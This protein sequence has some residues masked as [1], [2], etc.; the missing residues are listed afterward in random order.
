M[1]ID[2]YSEDEKKLILRQYRSL[3]RS[4]KFSKSDEDRLQIRKAFDLALD[5]HAGVKR[6]SGESYIFHPIAVAKI[7]SEEIGLG[8]TG[9][10]CALLH[11]VVED[12]EVTLEQIE[13]MFGSKIALIID[14]LTKISGVVGQTKS[15][16]AENFRK[17]LL[18]LSD[19]V[20]VILIKLADRLHN[21]RTLDSMR[22][23][24]QRKIASE[25]LFIYAPMAHRLGLYNIKTELEDLSLKFTEPELYHEIE[26]KLQ[27]TKAVRTRF[28]NQFTV[29]I[30]KSL[31]EHGINASIKGRT[32]SI[33]SIV[34]KIRNKK[35]AFEEI[36]DVF[37]IRIIIDAP[38]ER[39]K[40]EC[41]RV[42]SIV[43][44]FYKP[45][46]DRL[47]D[48]ISTPKS[49]GYES[50][51]TTVMSPTGKYVE[52]QI[53]TNRMDEIAE[54]G[55]AAHWKYKESSNQESNLDDWIAKIRELLENPNT[56]A[57]EFIDD[58]KLNLFNDE[59]FAF[60]PKGDLITMPK[61]ATA[62]DF[63]FE[64]HTE[65]GQHC[66]GAKVNHKLVPLSYEIKSG[67]QIE[68][69]T[70]K[71]KKPSEDW[72]SYAVTGKARA[73]IKTLLKEDKKRIGDDGKEILFRKLKQRK[74]E[75]NLQTI[76]AVK[77]FYQMKTEADLFYL[78]GLG[79]IDLT[80]L[81]EFK[82]EN[83]KVK[84]P[85]A[86]HYQKTVN[87]EEGLLAK[88]KSKS[89]TLLI[90]ENMESMDYKLAPCCNPIPGDEVFG[91]VTI[92]DGIK[93]HRINCPNAVQLMSNY[94]YRVV[95]A[96]WTTQSTISFL[97]GIRVTGFD[98]VGVVSEITNIISKDLN[99]NMRSISFD[100]DDG[101]FEGN[102][103]VFVHD[104]T[105]LT[106]L[107]SKI[108]KIE[109]VLSVERMDQ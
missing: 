70:S 53:R 63:A 60:T 27:K 30:Q 98:K 83:G 74:L 21:L 99:V 87:E 61:G 90:G 46:P 88:T 89:D 43:T 16:Q 52:V 109:G 15:I 35:V 95:K 62:L 13:S 100:S 19:D 11:D 69:I 108:S 41:W 106:N 28:I 3:L 8:T 71:K 96:R 82:V 97:A 23:D 12:T 58:F 29:P 75:N 56:N 44:D 14:G 101:I 17:V 37:A 66:M 86:T 40:S 50:L 24:K 10:V 20:R 104:T 57:I 78:I 107:S 49:N 9:I 72:L 103:K 55:Y 34:N 68:I 5:S 22:P 51:H 7:V 76:Q 26:S 54:K 93:I 94:A 32:K 59:I 84:A 2:K 80:R 45:N 92:N 91:F 65:I 64:I 85:H 79:K 105:H 73:K 47:R 33:Y 48:W 39:E 4:A 1:P 18:T 31:H 67:D 42:Y 36:F 102:I 6:K 38:F 25:T 81:K 77:D